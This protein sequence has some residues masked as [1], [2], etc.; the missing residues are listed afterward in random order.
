MNDAL[1]DHAERSIAIG[2]KSF[3]AASRLFDPDTRRSAVMLYAWCRHCDDVIDG[4][5]L[6]FGQQ[7]SDTP[8]SRARLEQ[9]LAATQALYTGAAP[10]EPAFAALGQVVAE[11]G[12]PQRYPLST[13]RAFA[14]TWSSAAIDA[15]RTPWSTATTSPAWSA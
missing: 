11:H 6:G 12:I 8:A 13:W 4:Q 7:A 10:S 15:S 5:Q 1:L 14:W 2:S 9:L 3:A